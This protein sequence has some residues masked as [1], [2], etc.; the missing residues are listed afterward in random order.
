LRSLRF[1]IVDDIEQKEVFDFIFNNFDLCGKVIAEF[2]RVFPI[3]VQV[4]SIH[5]SSAFWLA[6]L[7]LFRGRLNLALILSVLDKG[8]ISGVSAM[9]AAIRMQSGELVALLYA[10]QRLNG[11]KEGE[12]WN[13]WDERAISLIAGI[14]DLTCLVNITEDGCPRTSSLVALKATEG[15]HLHCL[16]YAHEQGYPWDERVTNESAQRGFLDCLQYAHENGCPWEGEVTSIA[17]QHGQLACLHYAHEHGCPWGDRTIDNAIRSGHVACLEYAL[18]KGCEVDAGVVQYVA[19]NGKLEYLRILVAAT[20]P[21]T[22]LD[23]AA[24]AAGGYLA[25][26]RLLHEKGCPWDASTCTAAVEKTNQQARSEGLLCL[27]YA[28]INGCPWDAETVRAA[29][30]SGNVM[31]LLY[32]HA[33][34]CPWDVYSCTAAACS[35]R[36]DALH[37]LYHHGCPWDET[38]TTAA[39]RNGHLACLRYLFEQG[40]LWDCNC[41]AGAAAGGYLLCL[42]YAHEHG[43]LWNDVTTSLAAEKGHFDC[44]QYA[45]EFGCPRNPSIVEDALRGGNW[46]CLDYVLRFEPI[47]DSVLVQAARYGSRECLE[48]LLETG[49]AI[50]ADSV[51]AAAAGAHRACMELGQNIKLSKRERTLINAA[52]RSSDRSCLDC[53]QIATLGNNWFMEKEL[54]SLHCHVQCLEYSLR[55]ASAA[56][57]TAPILTGAHRTRQLCMTVLLDAD[58]VPLSALYATIAARGD[59]ASLLM[60]EDRLKPAVEPMRRRKFCVL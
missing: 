32:L 7:R 60:L 48:G 26:L 34:Q 36:L 1:W 24:A 56:D 20:I 52:E 57:T 23:S 38:T 59:G 6:S 43:C 51:A 5:R 39:A 45:L 15:G 28:H 3:L 11:V 8:Y 54:M 13:G 31:A 21:L 49:M 27:Q 58:V 44:L 41:C 40:C 35:G 53:L 50:G 37:F 22:I 9:H 18:S 55:N 29:S 17:A 19:K 47:D 16:Q 42:Q 25:C 10:R 4:Q 2:S 46:R 33:H 12:G 14:G 30:S